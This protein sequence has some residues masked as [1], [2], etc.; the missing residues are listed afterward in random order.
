MTEKMQTTCKQCGKEFYVDVDDQF[1]SSPT[2]YCSRLCRMRA[3]N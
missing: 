2:E 3:D 1:G